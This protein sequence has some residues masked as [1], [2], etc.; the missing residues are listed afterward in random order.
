MPLPWIQRAP[1]APY[2]VTE[3]GAPWTP[4]GQNDAIA[5][6]EFTGLFRRRDLPAIERHLRHLADH[7]VTVLR[8]MMEY[9]QG[10]HRYIERPAGQ[11]V[12][13]MVTLWDDLFRLCESVG[14]R[15]LLTPFDTFFTWVHWRHHPYN[16]ANG[17][18]CEHPG[19]FLT[20]PDTREV[21]KARLAFA[22]ERWGGSGVLFAW[23]LWNEIHPAHAGG[24][25]AL[26]APFIA[27]VSA[28]LRALETRLHGRS[29]PQC[30]SIFGPELITHPAAVDSIFRHPA[31]DFA[32][33]HFY[34]H[35]TIDDPRDTVAAAISFGR[36]TREALS[37]ITDQRPFFDS[38]HG[39]IH[40]FKDKHRSLPEAFDDE[41]F[42]H[43]SWAHLAS[44]GA[45]GGMRWPNRN[46]HQLTPG[47]RRAQRAMSDFLPLVAWGRFHRR[48][49]NEEA[50]VDDPEVALFACGD[51]DQAVGWLLRRAP[52]RADGRVDD[53]RAG[54][55]T[56]RIPGLA[57]GPRR[58]TLWDTRVGREAGRLDATVEGNGWLSV[59]LPLG[60]DL[61]VAV[62]QP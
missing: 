25:P 5:W 46:P 8:L 45:G 10:R 50:E 54:P 9:A 32:S 28:H 62:T 30:V 27:D 35:G 2:F 59:T 33:S 16:R 26:F 3:D 7:G 17:G 4:I 11:F 13:A 40:K 6:P 24:D 20:C 22:T 58:V 23:D 56:L 15:V 53:S 12:P 43:I 60:P 49:L 31:L 21:I 52:L 48:N 51:A 39:P 41:Y 29:H 44:G 1:G 47:M 19:V 34:E 61:A 55:V 37:H 38:E 14:L 42:R 18:P 57:L 36:L